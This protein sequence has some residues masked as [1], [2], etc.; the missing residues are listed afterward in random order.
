MQ[1]MIRQNF[2][3]QVYLQLALAYFC[4]YIRERKAKG[5]FLLRMKQTFI[6]SFSS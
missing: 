1:K 4:H 5:I 2:R 3:F 6:K